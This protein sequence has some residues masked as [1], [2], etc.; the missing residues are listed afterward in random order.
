M[1]LI[2]LPKEKYFESAYFVIRSDRQCRE[3]KS[4]EMV[5]EANRIIGELEIGQDKNKKIAR[6][7]KRSGFSSF[8]YGMLSGSLIVAFVWL[9]TL[10]SL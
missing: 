10:I 1:M 4:G 8:M 9:I 5:K 2:Q 6:R 3:V 7:E